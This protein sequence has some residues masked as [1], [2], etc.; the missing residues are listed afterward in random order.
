MENFQ[1][2][3]LTIKM[4]QCSKI[5]EFQTIAGTFVVDESTD[6]KNQ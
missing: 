4:S 1:S 3:F 2:A 5:M 6:Q